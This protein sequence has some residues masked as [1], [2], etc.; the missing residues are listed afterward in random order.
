MGKTITV[1]VLDFGDGN[2]VN[3]DQDLNLD[4]IKA[5]ILDDNKVNTINYRT[6]SGQANINITTSLT[7]AQLQDRADASGYDHGLVFVLIVSFDGNSL[8]YPKYGLIN[9]KAVANRVEKPDSWHTDIWVDFGDEDHADQKPLEVIYLDE[10]YAGIYGYDTSE[11]ASSEVTAA[12]TTSPCW[13]AGAT[14]NYNVLV[15]RGGFTGTLYVQITGNNNFNAAN[16][17]LANPSINANIAVTMSAGPYS[18][19]VDDQLQVIIRD[20]NASGAI[21][22]SFRT[23]IPECVT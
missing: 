19:N 20:T 9:E 6:P 23:A 17:T 13:A 8:G 21:L 14:K 11:G 10:G 12:L 16:A 4:L 1:P 15:D 7:L 18:T 2:T 3:R 22:H 5:V